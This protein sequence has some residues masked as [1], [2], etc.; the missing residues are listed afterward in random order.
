MS[1]LQSIDVRVFHWINGDAQNPV[2]DLLMPWLSGNPLFIPAVCVLALALMWKGGARGRL[3]LAL[4]AIIL[5]VGDN[6]LIN[7]IKHL[8][9]R[10]RPFVS[11]PESRVLV[12]KGGSGSF[13]SSHA[14]TWFAATILALIYYPT[15]WHWVA[16]LAGL[17]SF[18][19]VY[20]GAHYPSDV[21][22]GAVLGAGYALALLALMEHGWRWMT[23]RWMPD[24]GDRLPSLL[25]NER[26]RATPRPPGLLGEADEALRR[27]K[28]PRRPPLAPLSGTTWLRLGYLVIGALWVFRLAYLAS[29][30]IELS[31]DETYQ[32]LWSKHPALSYFSKPPLIA[33][34]HTV[35]TTL[36][37]DRPFGVRFASPCIAA[38]LSLIVLRFMRGAVG[39]RS[40]FWLAL[41]LNMVP[42]LAVGSVLITVDPPMV[43][44]W[45]AAM[46]AGWRALQKDRGATPDWCWAGLFIGLSALSK[47]AGLYQLVCWALFFVAWPPARKHLRKPGPWIAL[48]IALLSLA[49][50]CVWN[51]RNNW[52]TLD[53]VKFNASRSEPWTP[54][55][56]YLR[57]FVGAEAALLNPV[58]FLAILPPMIFFRRIRS[59]PALAR[60]LF[61]MGA[62][63]FLGYLAFT[64]YKRVFPNWIAPAILPLLLLATLYWHERFKAG[65][66]WPRR[67]VIG[68]F[69]IGSP[70]IILMHD[71]NI[72][73]KITGKT[74]PMQFD[75]LRRVYGWT[76]VARVVGG[77]WR[78]LQAE[79]KPAFVIA[80]HYGFAAEASFYI[81]EARAAVKSDPIVYYKTASHPENQFYFWP[82]YREHRKGQNAVFLQE[83]DPPDEAGPEATPAGE[84]PPPVIVQEFQ[85]VT[86]IG[87]FPIRHRDRTLRWLQLYA[88]R[89]LL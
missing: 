43:L 88:C 8:I 46:F 87:I 37:G 27:E 89:N 1:F 15:R 84:A 50:V 35:G 70:I 38:I 28:T 40:A 20:V 25:P 85:S 83:V 44:F 7:P 23:R 32:W 62:P 66:P 58:L 81:P 82:G 60:F 49:P 26:M 22:L 68:A 3:F 80:S 65:S 29:D 71:T 77:E 5:F 57:D 79:G 42:L 4:L 69:V 63:V 47:Y 10:D 6:A 54:T 34:M 30:K 64:F 12:G 73:A 18:S 11:L 14:S 86:P 61:C 78:K 67:I 19:R 45:V 41:L 76:E 72:V 2:F 75:P 53:H 48:T 31:E 17:V 56:R 24:L 33:W 21:L 55:I 13:P 9:A 16:M 52:V 39:G 36:W 51:S 74:L 59:A